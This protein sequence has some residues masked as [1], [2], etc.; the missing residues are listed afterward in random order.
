MIDF[1]MKD[2]KDKKHDIISWC[3]DNNIPLKVSTKECLIF[4]ALV[5]TVENEEDA[6]AFKLRWL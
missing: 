2:N 3:R 4:F 1:E 6:V 5:Y